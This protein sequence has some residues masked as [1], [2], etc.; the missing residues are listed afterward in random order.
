MLGGHWFIGLNSMKGEL[1]HLDKWLA[2]G[3]LGEK[4][5]NSTRGILK[6]LK[7]RTKEEKDKE[8]VILFL[9]HHPF[10][11]LHHTKISKKIYE[12]VGHYLKD[13]EEFMDKINGLVDILLFGHDHEHINFSDT[14]LSEKYNIPYILSCGK[15]TIVSSELR[16]KKNM[17]LKPEPFGKRGLTA[18]EIEIDDGKIKVSSLVVGV[19]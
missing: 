17:R 6:D 1:G 2:D 15:S 18:W 4:Q 19:K 12:K 3:E 13:G 7:K 14:A 16:T 10:I 8:K 5:L 9:H 11:F